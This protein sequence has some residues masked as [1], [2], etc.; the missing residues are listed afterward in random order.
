MSNLDVALGDL[1]TKNSVRHTTATARASDTAQNDR[2]Q[3]KWR[4]RQRIQLL[5]RSVSAALPFS[6]RPAVV[7]ALAVVAEVVVVVVVHPA[8]RAASHADR[9]ASVTKTNTAQRNNSMQHPR[10]S[11]IRAHR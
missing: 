10:S 8:A 11:Y 3:T 5:P 4:L 2:E 9:K 1:V 6:A 7:V